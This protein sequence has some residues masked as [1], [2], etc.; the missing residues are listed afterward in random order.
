MEKFT[1]ELR[2]FGAMVLVGTENNVD[3]ATDGLKQLNQILKEN[4]GLVN[5]LLD[6]KTQKQIKAFAKM[7]LF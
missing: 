6:P 5:F 2:A 4:E 1:D 7:K 3:K